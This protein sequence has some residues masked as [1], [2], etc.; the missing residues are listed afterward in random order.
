M[1]NEDLKK[2]GATGVK[3]A[4]I[5]VTHSTCQM[6]KKGNSTKKI[7]GT[8]TGKIYFF[9]T[10]GPGQYEIPAKICRGGTCR[11][12]VQDAGAGPRRR[13]PVLRTVHLLCPAA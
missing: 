13:R 11:Q 4:K 1:E 7:R 12:A 9:S 8:M 2:L 3:A 6:R 5:E 10:P